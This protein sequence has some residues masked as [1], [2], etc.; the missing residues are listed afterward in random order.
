MFAS[1]PCLPIVL[2]AAFL[3]DEKSTGTPPASVENRV[4]ESDLSIVKLTPEAE[5]RLGIELASAQRETVE[6]SVL[7]PGVVEVPIGRSIALRAPIAGRVSSVSPERFEFGKGDVLLRLEPGS[8]TGD[9]S[10]VPADRIQIAK[11]RADLAVGKATAQGDLEGAKARAEAAALAAKR[12]EV[13]AQQGPGS[14]KVLEE[15]RG[16]LA[17]A[18]AAAHAAELRIDVYSRTLA[19]LDSSQSTAI[20]IRVPFAATL[21]SLGVADG[22][23]VESGALFAEVA[24]R[25]SMWIRVP[26]ADSEFQVLA[27]ARAVGL[28]M[29]NGHGIEGIVLASVAAPPR[30]HA[31][32]ATIDRIFA[33]EDDKGTLV[34]GQRLAVRLALASQE[35]LT[36]PRAAIV[37]DIHGGAWAYE[38]VASQQFARR[39]IEIQA[40]A[41]ER[42]VI[43]RGLK[44]GARIVIAGAAELFGTEFG[45]GK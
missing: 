38:A 26:I 43:G 13:L 9:G 23:I 22:Q 44:D 37:Y 20:E 10:F 39:R 1:L 21:Q 41:G 40:I 34:P 3:G 28:E 15:A 42:A 35:A 29:L 5:K 24:A 25:D 30:A 45:A 18:S 8:A 31:S 17:I 12:A 4:K 14:Q 11:A 7:R 6:K 16:E 32:N 36:I 19:A 27:S 33:A 2:L